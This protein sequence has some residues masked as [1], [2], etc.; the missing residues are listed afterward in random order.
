MDVTLHPTDTKIRK[1]TALITLLAY[2]KIDYVSYYS[3]NTSN[4]TL[5]VSQIYGVFYNVCINVVCV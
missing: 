2:L 1:R 3:C 4:F 5:L